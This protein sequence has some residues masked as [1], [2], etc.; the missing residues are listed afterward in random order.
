M[1]FRLKTRYHEEGFDTTKRDLL[2]KLEKEILAYGMVLCLLLISSETK[3]V[4][5]KLTCHVP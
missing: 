3:T 1:Q 5:R 2:E 4:D